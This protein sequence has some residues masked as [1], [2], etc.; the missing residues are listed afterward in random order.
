MSENIDTSN[1]QPAGDAP[2][3]PK[4]A[5]ERIAIRKKTDKSIRSMTGSLHVAAEAVGVAL[6][7]AED[8]LGVISSAGEPHNKDVG[9]ALAFAVEALN[10]LVKAVKA[11]EPTEFLE[12]RGGGGLALAVGMEVVPAK[13]S[14]AAFKELLGKEPRKVLAINEALG[15]VKVEGIEDS[16]PRSFIARKELAGRTIGTKPAA[17]S[18]GQPDNG[19]N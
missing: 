9:E 3:A 7:V 8:G 15:L 4:K 2:K 1:T 18:D 12:Y 10:G 5:P 14:T 17:P 13:A 6:E 19:Q 11:I 16:F